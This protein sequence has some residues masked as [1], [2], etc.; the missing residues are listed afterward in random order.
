MHKAVFLPDNAT[1]L[2]IDHQIVTMI[3]THSHDNNLVKRK[4]DRQGGG[5]RDAPTCVV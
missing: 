1:M 5:T 4:V 3:W 2:L